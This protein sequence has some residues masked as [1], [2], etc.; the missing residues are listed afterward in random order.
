M[1][2]KRP[3]ILVY[4][5]ETT[6]LYKYRLGA[7]HPGQP[8]LVQL[9]YVLI[10]E[11]GVEK[12]SAS[13]LVITEG[14]IPERVSDIHG[15]TKAMV[16]DYGVPLKSAISIFSHHMLSADVLVGHNISFD[17][18]IMKSC[19]H[20]IGSRSSIRTFEA[21]ERYCTA[22]LSRPIVKCPPTQKMLMA[23]RGGW[24]KPKLSE[25]YLHFAG[26]ELVG[27]HDAMVDV[28]AC[29]LVFES[30]WTDHQDVLG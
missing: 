29:A 10:G 6:G 30:L 27:A 12:A 19:F 4:D 28:R 16:M 23:G 17:D 11:D 5:T 18:N 14:D 3:T 25:A 15:V 13:M 8:E 24:K 7:D 1:T 9:A 26:K 21:M 22:D 20:R 2:R